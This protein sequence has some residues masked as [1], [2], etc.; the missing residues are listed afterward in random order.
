LLHAPGDSGAFDRFRA[1]VRALADLNHPHIVTVF[2][3]DLHHHAPYYT[4][5]YVPGGTL[6]RFVGARGPLS[7]RA[8]ALL[9][10]TVARAAHAAHARDLVHRDI[11][12]GNVLLAL[13]PD[14]PAGSALTDALVPKLSDF[15]LAKR[16]D[17]DEGL[18][19]GPGALGTPGFMAPEQAAGEPVT[20]R[21]DVYGLGATLYHALTGAAPFENAD[22]RAVLSRV[23]TAEPRRVRL[24]RPEVPV[25]LEAIVHKCLEIDPARRYPS[26]EALAADLERFVAGAPVTAEP[27]TP[28]RRTRKALVR[29]RGLL[30]RAALAVTVLGAVFALGGALS[31]PPEPAKV[32]AL[33]KMQRALGARKEVVLLGPTGEPLWHQWVHGPGAFAPSAGREGACSYQAFGPSMLDL[34]PDPMTDR[35]RVRAELCQLDVN[36]RGPDGGLPEGGVAEIGFYVGRQ[37]AT[38]NNGW[39]TEVCLCFRFT[40]APKLMAG[41]GRL[42]RIVVCESPTKRPGPI[43][44]GLG[45]AR[46]PPATALPGPW[47]VVELEVTPN[48]V[49]VWFDAP[50]TNLGPCAGL[51]AADL[52]RYFQV[53]NDSIDRFDPNN[54]LAH[55]AWNPRG[56]LGVWAFG[57]A[58]AVRSVTVSPLE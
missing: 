44:D 1:E 12:P 26:A 2:G 43:F 4:M 6:A 51:S 20:P 41:C 57:S 34:C 31:G 50:A 35:Y 25:E 49:R 3:A 39:R 8:A 38:G 17:R 42:D 27:L 29:R 28:L 46:F 47:H 40:E 13:R 53:P 9:L 21:T 45:A 30:G 24:L 33:K 36:E 5:E 32:K 52:A 11:K 15:G 22:A 37:P 48:G 18:T 14:L 7:A 58:L 23:Q 56:A 19:A 55:P 16:T 54:G 10:A